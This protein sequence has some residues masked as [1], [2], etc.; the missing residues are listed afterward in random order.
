MPLDGLVEG[1]GGVT[2]ESALTGEPVPAEHPAGDAVRS[3]VV[4][5]GGPFDLRVT[6]SAAESTY[7]GILRLVEEAE[8]STP[9]FVRLADHFAIWFLAAL[10]T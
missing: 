2:D 5:V 6:T 9:P 3:G 4:N 8:A 1:G 7:A 10:S